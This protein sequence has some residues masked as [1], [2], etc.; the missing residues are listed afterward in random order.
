MLENPLIS[1][2]SRGSSNQGSDSE[3]QFIQGIPNFVDRDLLGKEELVSL[4]WYRSNSVD[5]DDYLPLTFEIL[6]CDEFEER[7]KMYEALDIEP[8]MRILEI[9]CGT[10][11]DSLEI[12]RLL[13]G[14][15]ELFL[16][17]ISI[18]ILTIAIDKFS[19]REKSDLNIQFFLSSASSLPFPDNYFDRVFHFGGLNTFSNIKGSLKE[20]V[21]ITKPEGRVLLGDEGIPVWLRNTDF[22]KIMNATNHHYCHLPPLEDLPTEAKNLRLEWFMNNAFYFLVFNKVV[23]DS[24]NPDLEIPGVRGGTPRKRYDGLLEGIDPDLRDM[25]Y[26]RALDL[27]K[28]RVDFLEEV[29]NRSL[30]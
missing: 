16:Q 20:I 8:G 28:S 13:S 4:S 14:Q 1:S 23:E 11:R 17:D 25:V 27:G 26:K 30:G 24:F 6:K 3:I 29:L 21:R 7:R 22:F 2:F 12:A 9:G 15:G 19:Q 18:D 10:G 5:Y